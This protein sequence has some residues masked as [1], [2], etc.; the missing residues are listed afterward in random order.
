MKNQLRKV[1]VLSIMFTLIFTSSIGSIARAEKPNTKKSKFQVGKEDRKNYIKE[2]IQAK[3]E[4]VEAMKE[5]I[6]DKKEREEEIK[7]RIGDKRER[8]EE[9]KERIG[10]IKKKV[11]KEDIEKRLEEVKKQPKL[12]S[13]QNLLKE[14]KKSRKNA[15]EI[16]AEMKKVRVEMKRLIKKSYS[17]EELNKLRERAEEIKSKNPDVKVI[18]IENILKKK[19]HFKFDTPPVIKEGRTLI[20]VRAITEGLGAN[21]AWNGEERKVTVSKGDIEIVFQLED[22]KAFVNGE[23]TAIDVP[24]QI[25]NNRTIVPLRFI[26]EQLGLKVDYDQDTE[27]IEIEEEI[28]EELVSTEDETVVESVYGSEE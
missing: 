24:A 21:V 4:R 22:G 16:K 2:K 5:R 26:A 11:S 28:E 6:D 27:T 19:G 14:L 17:E 13:F 3:R 15:K 12:E 20:P 1:M 9:I 23:E 18:P 7:E 10:E 25:M 8:E